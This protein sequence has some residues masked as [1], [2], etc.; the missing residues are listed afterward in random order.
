MLKCLSVCAALLMGTG[1]AGI[2]PQSA[3]PVDIL[4]AVKAAD[5]QSESYQITAKKLGIQ[6]TGFR[7]QDEG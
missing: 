5:E 3:E 1:S 2:V 6:A 7:M 4:A